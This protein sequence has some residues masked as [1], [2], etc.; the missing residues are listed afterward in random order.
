L[1]KILFFW[2]LEKTAKIIK[3]S[4]ISAVFCSL[5]KIIKYDIWWL[6]MPPQEKGRYVGFQF[7][8]CL[9]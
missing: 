2:W 1:V 3:Y 9:V 7:I 4:V 5:P 6:L 8:D